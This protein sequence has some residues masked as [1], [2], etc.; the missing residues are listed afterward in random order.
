MEKGSIAVVDIKARRLLVLAVVLVVLGSSVFVVVSK[1]DDPV[2][3]GTVR[4]MPLGNSIT[5]G[6]PG[7][8]GYRKDLYLDLVDSGYDV[9]FVG[10]LSNGVGFDSDHEG[11]IGWYTAQIRNYVYSWLVANPADVILLHVGTNN[12]INGQPPSEVV[13]ETQDILDNINQ[14]QSDYEETVTVILARMQ[15]P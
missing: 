9:D 14:W 5:Y 10:G 6:F 1:A 13:A 7:D 3:N 2:A 12:I 11:H 8:E 15:A 4:I